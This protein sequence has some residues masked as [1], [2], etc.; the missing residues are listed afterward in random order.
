M[1]SYTETLASARA[2]DLTIAKRLRGWVVETHQGKS[3]LMSYWYNNNKLVSA[4]AV[5]IDEGGDAQL[6]LVAAHLNDRIGAGPLLIQSLQRLHQDSARTAGS[7]KTLA[8]V[9]R[10][11]SKAIN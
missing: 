10:K 11:S 8:E 4:H 3:V 7:K 5:F 2:H 1:V 9:L 6:D